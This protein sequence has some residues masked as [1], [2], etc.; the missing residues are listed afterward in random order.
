MMEQN[1]QKALFMFESILIGNDFAIRIF[2]ILNIP[3][4]SSVIKWEARWEDD[5]TDNE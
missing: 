2:F 1:V 5:M 4:L 3:R